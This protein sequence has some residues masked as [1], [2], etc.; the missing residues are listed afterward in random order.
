MDLSLV[1]KPENNP[2]TTSVTDVND[3]RS[4]DKKANSLKE[5]V[6]TRSNRHGEKTLCDR[7]IEIMNNALEGLS[8]KIYNIF[9]GKPTA[10]QVK[11]FRLGLIREIGYHLDQEGIYRISARKDDV[12]QLMA[13][14]TE[15]IPQRTLNG[16]LAVG[17]LK[18]SL[19]DAPL[20][21]P[22]T[23]FAK[24][25][26]LFNGTELK[27]GV[28]KKQI[29]DALKEG[30]NENDKE[31]FDALVRSLQDVANN[32]ETN[33]MKV[34]NLGVTPGANLFPSEASGA[35][36]LNEANKAAALIKGLLTEK[37]AEGS[38]QPKV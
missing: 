5:C 27:E 28:T 18:Q 35:K 33:K 30:L 31:V 11:D 14:Q 22:G 9:T 25:T 36:A 6:D 29:L 16:N 4:E 24:T 23:A 38:S 7:V 2:P 26:H 3:P 37:S 17:A 15:T 13:K 32:H 8:T 20:F 12:D 1:N 19:K 10:S 21:P 34:E